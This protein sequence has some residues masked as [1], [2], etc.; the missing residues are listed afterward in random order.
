[1]YIERGVFMKEILTRIKRGEIQLFVN[2]LEKYLSMVYLSARKNM[3][4]EDAS[5]A[6]IN[7]FSKLFKKI[8]KYRFW[9]NAEIFVTNN[10]IKLADEY[11]IDL[12]DN[13]LEQNDK[14]PSLVM[15]KVLMNLSAKEKFKKRRT[16]ILAVPAFL[17]MIAFAVTYILNVSSNEN[18]YPIGTI[19]DANNKPSIVYEK[20]YMEYANTG[21]QTFNRYQSMDII[22]E[23]HFIIK[24]LD[25]DNNSYYQIFKFNEPISTFSIDDTKSFLIKGS[26]E[27]LIFHDRAKLYRYSFNGYLEEEIEL[28]NI[29]KFSDDYQYFAIQNNGYYKIYST[30]DFSLIQ[31]TSQEIFMLLDNGDFITETDLQTLGYSEYLNH[32]DYSIAS[33][34]ENDFLTIDLEGNLVIYKFGEPYLQTKLQYFSYMKEMDLANNYAQHRFQIEHN[35]NFIIIAIE[36]D[37]YSGFE[38]IC[39]DEGIGVVDIRD[40]IFHSL[41]RPSA[42]ISKDGKMFL[43]PTQTFTQGKV[44]RYNVVYDMT[45]TPIEAYVL[46]R[47]YH[48]ADLAITG[49]DDTYYV[50]SVTNRGF[51]AIYEL[52]KE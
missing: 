31:K 32:D 36:G 38:I 5:R 22:D 37:E 10:L 14:V 18:F 46:D 19:V 43:L 6:T 21:T 39:R 35:D 48:M 2:L 41:Q 8:Q 17:I 34:I 29:R 12:D 1:M 3:N 13:Y 47:S 20:N 24:A 11:K 50:Y 33:F 52:T 49:F 40:T 25:H 23:K 16:F 42:S 28:S 45:K 30:K 4:E 15:R 7:I 44:F 9:Q 51:F 27:S 26:K